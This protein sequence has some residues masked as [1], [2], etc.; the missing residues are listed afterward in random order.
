MKAQSEGE[1]QRIALVSTPWPLYSRPSIQLGA[2]KAY[3]K[4]QFPEL[5]VQALH[6]Y[7][8][9][10]E[11]IG[12]KLYHAISERTWLAESVY[13]ALLFPER[14]KEIEK[15]FLHEA[16]G[17]TDL[18]K[19]DFD[20][21]SSQISEVSNS[22]IK[23]LDWASCG[24]VG[25]SVC[26]CQLSSSLYFIKRIKQ[27]FPQLPIVVGGSAFAGDMIPGVLEIFPEVDFVINGEGE[28]PLSRLVYHMTNFRGDSDFPP[29]PGVITRN[30]VKTEASVTFWQL[31]NLNSLPPPDYDDYFYLL[32]T[33]DPE[34]TFFPTLSA[35][36]SRGCWW[37]STRSSLA[38][39][40]C[41]FC[42]LN[43]Q[44]N[45]YRSK[46][47]SQLASE[48]DHLTTKYKSLSVAFMDNLLPLRQSREIFL[49]L[50]KLEKDLRLFAEIRSTTPREVLNAMRGA[51]MHEVQ[52]GIEAL[53]TKLLDKLNK[54]TTAIQNLEIMKHC[55][56]LGISN[57]S[58]LILHFPGSDAEDVDETLR[59]LEFA[60][61]FRPLRFVHFWLGLGSPV[62][63]HPQAFGLKAVSNHP[64]YRVLF[65]PEVCRSIR[66]MIQSYRGDLGYQQKLWQPVKK[67]VRA[68]K[69][70]YNR[71][72]SGPS[73]SP[74]LSFRDGRDFLMIRH[75]R[76][77]QEPMTHRLVGTSRAIYLFCQTHR[78]LKRIVTR[79]PN[80]GEDKIVPFLKMMVDK[81]LMFEENGRYLSLAVRARGSWVKRQ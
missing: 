80:A 52:I 34:K 60:L 16:R 13:G 77:G 10:A 17:K 54:G 3:L 70:S 22:L 15:I 4:D 21:L 36:V 11:R 43:L 45:G 29:I 53:S 51:G 31:E 39:K 55:E 62:W 5:K 50:G 40:G 6:V 12:Y 41:T 8:K 81:Q 7:L 46:G 26:L 69:K 42:N 9:V 48:V 33:L 67:K 1:L 30:S 58:N 57:I 2:L 44:W 75:R 20:A 14:K 64:N 38:D 56:E 37:R 66:F 28:L 18:R 47:V 78:S 74:I 27:S 59:A 49:E 71:L 19:V 65:P 24:L 35:E 68:W 76:H 72:H 63:Q 23:A 32:K 73:R 25:F 61:P 79:F